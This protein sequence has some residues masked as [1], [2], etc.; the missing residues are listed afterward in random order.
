MMVGM[1]AMM[2]MALAM[3]GPTWAWAVAWAAWVVVAWAVAHAVVVLPWDLASGT[4]NQ[5]APS[6][7]PGKLGEA[8]CL[9]A[10]VFDEK[11][12]NFQLQD[13]LIELTVS[14]M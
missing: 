11:T 8:V 1:A 3:I 10:A 2:A 7:P 4:G 14:L 5:S 6:R 9:N 12:F 13:S